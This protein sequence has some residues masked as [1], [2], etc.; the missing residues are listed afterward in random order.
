MEDKTGLKKNSLFGNDVE[1]HQA[2]IEEFQ[3]KI[4]AAKN[5][6]ITDDFMLISRIESLILE[7]GMD[8]ALAR[9][10]AYIDA[11]SDGIMIHS[12]QKSP[13]EIFAFCQQYHRLPNAVPLMVVPSSFNSVTES[14]WIEHG[15]QIVV[16]A[17]HMLRSAYPAML[18]V[19]QSILTHGRSQEAEPD[20]LSIKDILELIPVPN[21]HKP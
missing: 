1:Q 6:Q 12:R 17:N 14:E 8:D 11:G 10:K 19:A 15:V 2:T 21:K 7:K 9:T 18:R 13:A 3:A 16:H 4:Y 5:A 20:C